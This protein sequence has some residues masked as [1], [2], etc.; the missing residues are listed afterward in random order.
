[1]DHD[2]GA[3]YLRETFGAGVPILLGSADAAG[4]PYSPT[5]VDS[6]NLEPQAFSM[7]GR[8]L[9][10]L[11]TPGHTPGSLT[12]VIS[13]RDN[14]K[15]VRVLVVGGSAMPTDIAGARSYLDGVERTYALAQ[16]TGV[17]GSLHPHPAFDASGRNFIDINANGRK[18]PSQFVIGN[19]RILRAVAI[20]RE[21]S[22]ANVGRVDATAVI[23]V[24]RVTSIKFTAGSPSPSKIS[25]RV[26]SAWGPVAHQEVTF[27]L[28]ET[29]GTCVATT[30]EH[31]V[32]RC[33]MGGGL[34]PFS[35][36]I[37]AS[38]AGAES[39]DFLDLPSTRTATVTSNGHDGH[40]GRDDDHRPDDDH[41][42]D[43]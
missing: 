12:A 38:F 36:R 22:A 43:D 13:V 16:A 11:S 35:D 6:S 8:N 25:A 31:G 37:T 18:K 34:R 4:K 30:N 15:E 3:L 7:A 24:W 19:A 17:V 41:G 2:G 33:D 1:V 42:H 21:C 39:A 23:P 28:N 29:A 5:L 27:T 20:L 10:L 40:H 14:G 26:T 32:A 9:T